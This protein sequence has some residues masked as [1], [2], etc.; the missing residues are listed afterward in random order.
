VKRSGDR[1]TVSLPVPLWRPIAWVA[2]AFVVELAAAVA[3]LSCLAGQ[4]I[5]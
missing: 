4:P 1:A 2:V 5:D 3:V